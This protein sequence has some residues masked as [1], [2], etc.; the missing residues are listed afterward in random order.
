MTARIKEV[1]LSPDYFAPFLLIVGVIWFSHEMILKAEVPF[2]RDL[3]PYFYPMRFSLAQS[4]KIGEFPLWDRH[5]A[6]GFPLLADFQSATFYPPHLVF[7]LFPFFGAISLLFVFHYLVAALGC[8][9]LF[10]YWAYPTHLSLIAAMTFTFGGVIV[11]LTN[12]LNHF[13]T[14]VWIPWLILAGERT[15]RSGHRGDFVRLIGVAL[16]Q[17]LGGSPEFYLMSVVLLFLIAARTQPEY[18]NGSRQKSFLILIFANAFVVGLSMFQLLPTM[19]LFFHSRRPTRIPYEEAIAWSLNPVSLI[20]LFFLDKEVS[21]DLFNGLRPFFVRDLPFF[22]SLYMGAISLPGIC[23]W[24]YYS[25]RKHKMLL[26]GTI[27]F[28]LALA[29]GKY[30]PIYYYLF[31]YIPLFGVFR[32][33]EKFVFLV[34][35]LLLFVTIEGLQQLFRQEQNA[36]RGPLYILG[37]I[38]ALITL[39]YVSL[40]LKPA[41]LLALFDQLN[42]GRPA[43]PESLDS[44]S[45]LFLSLE[46]QILLLGAILVLLFLYNL[47]RIGSHIFRFLIIALV[48]I[49]LTSAHRPYQFLLDPDI[50]KEKP[51]VLS[52]PESQPYR[53]FSSLP[54]LHPSIFTFKLRPF[55][56][57]IASQ[58]AALVPNTGIFYGFD[59]LQE[60][61]AMGRQTYDFFLRAAK[62]LPPDKF[63]PF[64][65][66]LNVKYVSS[67]TALPEGEISLVRYFPEFPLW[68]YRVDHVV[69][70][71][72]V[73]SKVIVEKDPLKILDRLSSVEFDAL[74]EVVLERT[75]LGLQQNSTVASTAQAKIVDYRNQKVVIQASLNTPG[76]LVLAD[77]FYPGW[78]AYVDGR[79]EEI[80]RANLFFRGVALS[81]GDH[82]VEFR[83]KPVSFKIGLTVSLVTLCGLL[84]IA[85]RGTIFRR[86]ARLSV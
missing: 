20:N 76:I 48:F 8:Y 58:W 52:A 44:L 43:L 72:Y 21:P 81:Q 71:A 4:F 54:Y 78:R 84:F 30:T 79:E 85:C 29:L 82:L 31:E 39:L 65:G 67:F 47:R 22:V 13:Q 45:S 35:V 83:Y 86:R 46:R 59:Y 80:L 56:E 49:D 75:P 37:S 51:T 25:S 27:S 57:V 69:S 53:L 24:L 16:L 6:M 41:D 63:Y 68:L 73:V 23:S 28:S 19:E 17:F 36:K 3:G 74:N 38:L 64:L 40:R 9:M 34:Y 14:A 60:I 61:D 42:A 70:R 50:V 18:G 7:V 62:D 2:F 32:F 1:K 26:L 55:P 77:S 11:S 66:A 10:R 5:V 33:P 12:L 15:F